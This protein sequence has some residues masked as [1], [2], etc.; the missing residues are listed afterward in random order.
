MLLLIF[1]ALLLVLMAQCLIL[2]LLT[3]SSWEQ[4]V[5]LLPL[6]D[7][8]RVSLSSSIFLTLSSLL[9]KNFFANMSKLCYSVD[10]KSLN[11]SAGKYGV[12]GHPRGVSDL[13]QLQLHPTTLHCSSTLH[14]RTIS[15]CGT[16]S[17]LTLRKGLHFSQTWNAMPE[18]TIRRYL[19]TWTLE[20]CVYLPCEWGHVFLPLASG[21][22]RDEVSQ[23]LSYGPTVCQSHQTPLSVPYR[24]VRKPCRQVGKPYRQAKK[25]CRKAGK[26]CR[27][28]EK[29]RWV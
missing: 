27:Q 6:T 23:G 11:E 20:L 4:V 19:D 17:C 24:Q 28:V 14:I 8:L 21:S 5:R 15:L 22:T 2:V 26:P 12:S 10:W 7:C 13:L 18:L 29:C 1:Q 9:C 25:P 3:P 16:L